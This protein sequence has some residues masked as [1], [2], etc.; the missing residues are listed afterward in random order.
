MYVCTTPLA[1]LG[2]TEITVAG[3]ARAAIALWAGLVVLLICIV[4]MFRVPGR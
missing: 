3:R 4:L 1:A 2:Q